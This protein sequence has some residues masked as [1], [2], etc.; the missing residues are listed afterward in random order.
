MSAKLVKESG[1]LEIAAIASD[2]T[3]NIFGLKIIESKIKDCGLCVIKGTWHYS[4]CE[5]PYEAHAIINSF[6]KLLMIK[7]N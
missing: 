7:R 1:S 4:F 5:R 6:I 3:A 2:E